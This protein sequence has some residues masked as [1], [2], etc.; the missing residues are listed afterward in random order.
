MCVFYRW[1][2]FH[3]EG[4]VRLS[5]QTLHVVRWP[6]QP[7]SYK[8]KCQSGHYSKGTSLRIFLVFR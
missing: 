8:A 4:S 3:L 5:G 7:T 6:W 2:I 1:E